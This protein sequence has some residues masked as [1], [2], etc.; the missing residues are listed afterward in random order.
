[1]DISSTPA[2]DDEELVARNRNTTRSGAPSSR[3][4]GK[5]RRLSFG[6]EQPDQEEEVPP[7]K[8][9]PSE[10]PKCSGGNPWAKRLKKPIIHDAQEQLTLE[11]LLT[12][13]VFG[14]AAGYDGRQMS[15]ELTELVAGYAQSK[16]DRP[17]Q[18]Q[19]VFTLTGKEGAQTTEQRLSVAMMKGKP[20][21][22]RDSINLGLDRVVFTLLSGPSD[23]PPEFHVKLMSGPNATEAKGPY[24]PDELHIPK[25]NG[26]IMVRGPMAR[27]EQVRVVHG[28]KGGSVGSLTL[29]ADYYTRRTN[30]QTAAEED[31]DRAGASVVIR[32]EARSGATHNPFADSL[33]LSDEAPRTTGSRRGTEANNAMV[34]GPSSGKWVKAASLKGRIGAAPGLNGVG[35]PFNSGA[36][37]AA[38]DFSGEGAD[39]KYHGLHLD[40][41]MTRLA[42]E[43][44][45]LVQKDGSLLYE[46]GKSLPLCST[47]MDR[48]ESRNR[49]MS[50]LVRHAKATFDENNRDTRL[51]APISPSPEDLIQTVFDHVGL[52]PHDVVLDLGCGD[53]RWVVAAALRGCTGRGLDLNEDL[54]EKG[55]RAAAEAGVS[56]SVELKNADMFHAPLAG[57]TIIIVYLFREGLASMKDKLETEADRGTRVVSVGFQIRGWV[58]VATIVIGGLHAY[59]YRVPDRGG[60]FAP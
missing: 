24:G 45:R 10:K 44:A 34:I 30:R 54:L 48:G 60:A 6:S 32:A 20:E 22:G 37:A 12:D 33:V 52:G 59:I 26:R 17:V 5:K 25:E 29:V 18:E 11:E 23:E 16:A 1:M 58:S 13:F 36:G 21:L 47:K 9:V 49:A 38:R 31:R 27:G 53:G 14:V 40:V 8:G 41:P 39:K 55:R 15:D 7:A 28:V 42:A 46:E 56:S 2:S 51:V 19:S 57:S 35:K 50:A 4:A 3:R 43:L